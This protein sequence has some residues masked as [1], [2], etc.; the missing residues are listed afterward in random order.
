V[1]ESKAGRVILV[2]AGPGAPDLITLRGERALRVADAVVY[3]ALAPSSLLGLAPPHAERID[4]GRR[5]HT[6][7]PRTQDEVNALLVRL[8]RE[9]KRVVRLKGGDPY[10]FGRGG[11][12]ARACFDAGV[13]CEVIPGVSSAIGALTYAGIPVTD[14]QHSASFAVVTGHKD[15][16]RVR[17]EIRWDALATATDTLVLLMGMKNLP[18]LVGRLVAAGRAADTPA[19][20]VMNGTRPTQRVVEAPLGEL[21]ARVAA[22]GLGAPAAV[23]IGDVVRL[24]R[25][26]AWFEALPLF[27]RRVLLT[28]TP[29]QASGLARA[30]EE[31]GAE[32]VQVPTIRVAPAPPGPELEAALAG[33]PEY[34]WI[35]FTSANAVRA[36]S[37]LMGGAGPP[38]HALPARALCVGPATSA[39][40]AQAGFAVA[41]LPAPV[42]DAEALLAALRRGV[43]V[44]GSRVLWPRGAAAGP[45]LALGL[46]EA[47]AWVD[48]VVVYRTEAAAF[49]APALAA[50]LAEGSLHAL[51]FASPSAARS[52]AAGMGRDGMAAAR[53]VVVAAIGQVTASALV[54]LGLS[55]DAVA[56]SPEPAA[57]VT[58]LAG[59]FEG[60]EGRA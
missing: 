47:G 28:R 3:D 13:P 40:A 2:G 45:A 60:R 15:P 58:A 33:L 24:R 9:G 46:R 42:G 39:A 55:A 19:A 23:V 6:D 35:V 30:L 12:E 57:L 44:A 37:A 17:E 34:D 11:E 27:G 59:A 5:G 56:E 26:L 21:P 14:R 54:E 38:P 31:A 25:E 8:A 41:A 29:E 53:R 7:P 16:A 43:P 10:V 22:A 50:A 4:V 18:E 20:A 52:F 1:S 51:T 36:L 48:D 49:D 32:P